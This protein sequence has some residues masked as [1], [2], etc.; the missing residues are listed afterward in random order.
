[1]THKRVHEELLLHVLH[2]FKDTLTDL[3]VHRI[4]GSERQVNGVETFHIPLMKKLEYLALRSSGQRLGN[5]R[6]AL[7]SLP[8]MKTFRFEK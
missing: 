7:E 4:Y 5:H 6:L 3:S 8:N 2:K 1:M